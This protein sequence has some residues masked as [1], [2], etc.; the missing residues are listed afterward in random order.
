MKRYLCTAKLRNER[1]GGIVNPKNGSSYIV[2]KKTFLILKYMT[3]N[4]IDIDNSEDIIFKKYGYQ[5]VIN[6]LE[7]HNNLGSVEVV[8]NEYYHLDDNNT[9]GENENYENKWLSY[10]L[11]VNIIPFYICN[12]KCPFC[13]VGS[14][15]R[16][17]ADKY[18]ERWFKDVIQMSIQNNVIGIN[19]LGG[20]PFLRVEWIKYLLNKCKN[21]LKVIISTNGNFNMELIDEVFTDEV[22]LK[23]VEIAVS[24]HG[25]S[26]NAHDYIINKSGAF[27]NVISNI[28]YMI[29][30]SICVSIHTVPT[31]ENIESLFELPKLCEKIGVHSLNLMECR[32]LGKE[33]PNHNI[34]Y[35]E[36][37][38]FYKNY[39]SSKLIISF[40]DSFNLI[41]EKQLTKFG[42]I[43]PRCAAGS[44][45][46]CVVPGGDIYP[47]PFGTSS[48]DFKIGSIYDKFEKWW[49]SEKWDDFRYLNIDKIENSDCKKCRDKTICLGGCP[50]SSYLDTNSFWGGDISCPKIK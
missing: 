15:E 45:S 9:I 35:T 25:S 43:I 24:L 1:F 20:E 38:D 30:K 21:R 44:F 49:Y 23:N 48:V 14:V 2:S 28:K 40:S 50:V 18:P 3:Y 37:L 7:F 10:P 46:I 16:Q 22:D 41:N 47:C 31:N 17:N 11:W 29:L 34:R 36:L 13:L 4:S 12:Q 19:L 42:D 39:N 26:S 5:R 33:S 6:F 32:G 8:N 27:N